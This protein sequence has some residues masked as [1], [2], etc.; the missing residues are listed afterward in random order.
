MRQK[1]LGSK[2]VADKLVNN[3]ILEKACKYS[4]EEN[5]RIVLAGLRGEES[6]AS[7]CCFEGID[8]QT[9]KVSDLAEL[10]G[11]FYLAT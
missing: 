1:F 10:H 7:L 4:T 9:A 3:I 11:S 5:I 8:A 6:I 2:Y